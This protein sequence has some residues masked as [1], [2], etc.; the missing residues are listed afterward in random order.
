[1]SRTALFEAVYEELFDDVFAYFNL[2]FGASEAEDL[3][4]EIFLKVWQHT[5]K[6]K[7]PNSWRAFVFRCA[8]N[9]KNDVLRR[10]YAK[11]NATEALLKQT[12]EPI[13]TDDL[14]HIGV[15]N[16]LAT[17]PLEERELL[18]LKSFGFTS[19]EIGALLEITP[20]TVRGRLQ[21]AKGHFKEALDK[22][23]V[24]QHDRSTTGKSNA[25]V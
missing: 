24:T 13:A 12:L 22:E 9:L 17:L 6:E 8:V 16:A 5:E 2:C 10:K 23:E 7:P 20:S 11:A 1:M 25:S 18:A 21:K 19:D 15:Q 4:Q 3:A 14:E